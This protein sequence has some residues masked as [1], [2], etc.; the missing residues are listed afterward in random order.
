M[1]LKRSKRDNNE[2]QSCSKAWVR[3]QS[4]SKGTALGGGGLQAERDHRGKGTCDR[5][6]SPTFISSVNMGR[7]YAK[8]AE[9]PKQAGLPWWNGEWGR[10]EKRRLSLEISVSGD[11][12]TSEV[13]ASLILLRFFFLDDFQ[14]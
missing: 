7:A 12:S 13:P 5:T 1:G 10:G 8:D 14:I 11:D 2:M 9:H 3:L 4:C 6:R